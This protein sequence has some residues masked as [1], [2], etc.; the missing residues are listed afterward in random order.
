MELLDAADQVIRRDGPS[1]SMEV[2]AADTKPIL[3]RHFGDKGGLYTALAVRRLRRTT[4]DRELLTQ[5]VALYHVVVEA[6][7]AIA[8]Q[9]FIQRYL[10]ERNILPGFFEGMNNVSRDESRHVALGVKFLGE[11]V[12]E[13]KGCRDAGDRPLGARAAVECRRV[14]S[15]RLRS[16]LHGELRLHPRGDL[17]VLVSG[18][19]RPSWAGWASTPRR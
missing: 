12:R 17:R 10:R 14:R 9:H 4:D 6:M 2:I 1:V 13:S 5:S 19:S 18:A 11:L 3:Y 7:L 15:S 16:R 8:G